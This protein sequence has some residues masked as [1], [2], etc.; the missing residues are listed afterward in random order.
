M[1][2]ERDLVMANLEWQVEMRR[3]E[4]LLDYARALER[5][6]QQKENRDD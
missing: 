5:L 3:L 2:R 6:E 1:E 4:R